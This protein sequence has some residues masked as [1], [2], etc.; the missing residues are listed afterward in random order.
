MSVGPDSG[1]RFIFDG[2]I[3]AIEARLRRQ[4]AAAHR[5]LRRGR[6]DAAADDAADA[7]LH[8][9]HRCRHR[10]TSLP[11]STGCRPTRR[12]RRAE[13]RRCPAAQPERSG[14]SARTCPAGAGRAVVHRPDTALPVPDQ[15]AADSRSPWYRAASC[16]RCPGTRRPR[17]PAQRGN[18][19]RVRRIRQE[20]RS[21]SEPG[22]TSIKAEVAAGRTGPEIVT[23]ALGSS[24]SIR[25]REAA[26]SQ[27]EASAWA[28]AEMLRR[29]RAFVT[30]T[31]VTTG[32]PDMVVGSL[33]TPAADRRPIRR[34][35]LLRHPRLPYVRPRR[36]ASGP[37]SRPSAPT[38]NEVA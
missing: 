32:S 3:S 1:Q 8:E 2:V 22:A 10:S 25:V 11:A 37:A 15:P 38:L 33:L 21:T 14:V 20:G 17:P 27:A 28:K 19:H 35:R 23:K 4:P 5:G 29:A 18:R 36:R 13:V 30:A 9:G 26:L 12:H 24:S 16:S 7:D 31:G 34:R 6:A